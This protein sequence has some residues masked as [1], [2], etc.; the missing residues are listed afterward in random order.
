MILAMMVVYIVILHLVFNMFWLYRLGN[1]IENIQGMRVMLGLVV[2]TCVDVVGRYFFSSPV[3]GARSLPTNSA[4]S[5]M[6]F[7]RWSSK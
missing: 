1:Q 6:W 2:L 3:I 7:Q 4:F 5:T